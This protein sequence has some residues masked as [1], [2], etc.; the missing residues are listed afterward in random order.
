MVYK[1]CH[2]LKNMEKLSKIE[3]EILH[4]ISKGN[5]NL[6]KL[7]ELIDSKP[8]IIMI[9]KKLE[10]L[11]LLELKYDGEKIQE[12]TLSQLG[13]ETLRSAAYRRWFNKLGH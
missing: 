11:K 9:I 8:E 6:D 12:F 2:I 13:Q 1:L 5:N 7:W 4:L 10:Q 3:Y